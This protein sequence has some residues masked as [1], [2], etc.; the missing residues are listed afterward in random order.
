MVSRGVIRVNVWLYNMKFAGTGVCACWGFCHAM[1]ECSGNGSLL[2]SRF[3]CLH[4]AFAL[5]G[6]PE[7]INYGVVPNQVVLSR[8]RLSLR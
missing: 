4:G 2:T 3:V 6:A 8:R 5:Q 1:T 7:V